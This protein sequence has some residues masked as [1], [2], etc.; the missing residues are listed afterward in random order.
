[1]NEKIKVAIIGLGFGMEFIPIYQAHP[2][3]DVFAVCRRDREELSEVGKRFNIENLFTDWRDLLK[4]DRLLCLRSCFVLQTYP[5]DTLRIL[6]DVKSA[7]ALLLVQSGVGN[8]TDIYLVF[9]KEG[10]SA[11]NNFIRVETSGYAFAGRFLKIICSGQ[12]KIC[13]FCNL[14]Q[15]SRS[16]VFAHPLGGSANI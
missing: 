7:K 15:G 1:M 6:R 11:D 10:V 2:K 5:T 16:R 9:L 8:I 13:L 12:R 14:L 4:I 3:V